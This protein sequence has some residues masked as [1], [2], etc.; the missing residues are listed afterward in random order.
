[1]IDGHWKAGPKALLNKRRIDPLYLF[2]IINLFDRG[3]VCYKTSSLEAYH[4]R[5]RAWAVLAV[6]SQ[7]WV[8]SQ[9]CEV[10]AQC[11]FNI[12]QICMLGSAGVLAQECR[13]RACR[14]RLLPSVSS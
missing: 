14:V 9:Y 12:D 2:H 11:T 5:A 13:H 7:I 3:L 8:Q 6:S 1:M 4:V 10:V